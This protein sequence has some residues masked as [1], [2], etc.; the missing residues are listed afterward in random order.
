MTASHW[1]MLGIFLLIL[2]SGTLVISQLLLSWWHRKMI[3]E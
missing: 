1:Q 2:G 3:N